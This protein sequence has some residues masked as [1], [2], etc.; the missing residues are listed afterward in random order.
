MTKQ[1]APEAFTCSTWDGQLTL[2][3]GD[4][5]GVMRG[6][7]F[8]RVPTIRRV[9]RIT[10]NGKRCRLDDGSE[11]NHHGERVGGSSSYHRPRLLRADKARDL[12]DP[13]QNVHALDRQLGRLKDLIDKV[14]QSRSTAD[15]RCQPFVP[16]TEDERNQMIALIR[17]L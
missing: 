13:R 10:H 14:I 3:V 12:A 16:L 17:Q 2:R 5:V 6:G 4:D 8:D 7:V 11:W 1:T 9:D 15:A